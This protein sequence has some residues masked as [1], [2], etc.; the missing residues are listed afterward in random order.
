MEQ[1]RVVMNNAMREIYL[2]NIVA[3]DEIYQDWLEKKIPKEGLGIVIMDWKRRR[4]E[5][6]DLVRSV[7]G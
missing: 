6:I 7:D 4:Q 2:E 5:L 1:E 3:F